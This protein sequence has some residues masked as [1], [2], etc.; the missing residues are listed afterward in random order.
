M[1]PGKEPLA[2]FTGVHEGG[3]I[4]IHGS[5]YDTVCEGQLE[6]PGIES[7]PVIYCRRSNIENFADNKPNRTISD[8]RE[9]HADYFAAAIAMPNAT[10]RPVVH[11]ILREHGIRTGY[12]APDIDDDSDYLSEELLPETIMEIY[13]VSKRAAKIKLRKAGFVGERR[14]YGRSY[15]QMRL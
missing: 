8:W 11:S 12:I 6:L 2:L 15:P 10:F 13:G 3:H 5:I 9:H 4:L 1:K 7:Q 14:A